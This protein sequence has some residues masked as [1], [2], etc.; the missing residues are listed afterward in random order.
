MDKELFVELLQASSAKEVL[1]D[2]DVTRHWKEPTI[3]REPHICDPDEV[4]V[5]K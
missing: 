3:K 2:N 4:L 1:V 5:I